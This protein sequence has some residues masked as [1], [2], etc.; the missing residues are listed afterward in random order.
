M[1]GGTVEAVAVVGI[2]VGASVV[3][4]SVVGIDVGA[5]IVESRARSS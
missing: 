3:G 2:G 4:A 1:R 5:E